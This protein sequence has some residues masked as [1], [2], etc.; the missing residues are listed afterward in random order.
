[1]LVSY[2]IILVGI[3]LAVCYFLGKDSKEDNRRGEHGFKS[4]N[5]SI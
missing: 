2:I 5:D 4:L 3:H 1:M